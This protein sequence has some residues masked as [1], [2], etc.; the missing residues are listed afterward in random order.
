MTNFLDDE[1]EFVVHYMLIN[2]PEKTEDKIPADQPDI[3]FYDENDNIVRPDEKVPL[4]KSNKKQKYLKGEIHYNKKSKDRING[5]KNLYYRTLV[6]RINKELEEEFRKLMHISSKQEFSYETK[7][8]LFKDINWDG[9][10]EYESNDDNVYL[11]N[12]N[13]KYYF[14]KEEDFIN[15]KKESNFIIN[16]KQKTFW[17]GNRPDIIKPT[18]IYTTDELVLAQ[19]PIYI[20]S[21]KR[22]DT[23]YTAKSLEELGISNYY[24]VIRPEEDEIKNYTKS[25]ELHKMKGN[26]L[27]I[28][29][30]FYS[31]QLLKGNDFSIIPRN[32]A[33]QNA[34]DKGYTHHWCLDDNI[35][36]FFRKNNGS[37]LPIKSGICFYFV[38]EYIKK[39]NNVYQ[40]GL[41]YSHLGFAQ[42]GIR[43]PIIKNSRIYSCILLKHIDGFRWEGSYNEDTDLSLRLLKAGYATM[44]FENFLCGKKTTGSVRGGNTDSAYSKKELSFIDKAD[45]LVNKHPDV[46]RKVIKYGRTHHF[47]DYKPFSNNKLEVNDYKINIPDIQLQSNL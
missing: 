14:Y 28:D 13:V 32:Y 22:Y 25:M 24:I 40:A 16:D 6:V 42:S 3:T 41:Q 35:K 5:L 34:I 21:Y 1:D 19:Y 9:C 20:V 43:H 33:Y 46:A 36:G 37:I 18:G 31:N 15:F 27:I 4:K 26:L 47:V 8:D 12:P 38:E 39:Y 44:T 30:D 45:E 11:K 17:Y 7:K 23:I 2:V 10:P 29:K